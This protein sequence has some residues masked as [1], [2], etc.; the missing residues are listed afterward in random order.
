MKIGIIGA[1]CY[2]SALA[3]T[4]SKKNLEICLYDLDMEVIR[5]LNILK[6]LK[7][8]KINGNVWGTTRIEELCENVDLIILALPSKYIRDVIKKLKRNIEK[9]VFIVNV[10]KG[11]EIST[12]NRISQIIKEE[13]ENPYVVLSGPSHAEE[14]L[15]E[16]PTVL[17]AASE[18]IENARIVR[19]IFSGEILRVYSSTDVIGVEISG[20]I[21]NILA[22][23]AGITTGIGYG[24]NTLVALIV[25]GIEEIAYIA[26]LN[27]GLEK[28]IRGVS[29]I[30]DAIVTCMSKHSR[31]RKV[32]YLIGAGLEVKQAVESSTTVVEGIYACQAMKKF[33]KENINNTPIIK[34]V[35]EICLENELARNKID[36]L[37]KR[38]LRD[39]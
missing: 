1:G 7:Q 8:K 26:K 28:T 4:L 17:I 19:D 13:I 9:N 16:H 27:G 18:N 37:M 23:G 12:G 6:V 32:G 31:N 3:K 30:G 29:G 20:A 38:E 2:G 5:E 11:F 36:E 22:L 35:C 39:E 14:I 25:R 10:S 24:D 33:L 34:A 21:K 15:E